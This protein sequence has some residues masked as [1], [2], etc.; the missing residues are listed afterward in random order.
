MSYARTFAWP[1][2]WRTSVTAALAMPPASSRLA[3]GITLASAVSEEACRRVNL[4]FLDHRN[5][6]LEDYQS[7]MDTRVVEDAGRD[8]YLV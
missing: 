3:I 8:L 6:Q 2:T 1:H 4:G 5:F 7:D